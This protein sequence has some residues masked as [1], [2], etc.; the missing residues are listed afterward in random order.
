MKDAGT[1]IASRWIWSLEQT[2]SRAAQSQILDYRGT[3][4]AM[5][6][7]IEVVLKASK[8]EKHR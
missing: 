4:R 8:A 2:A 5:H 1:W 3:G 6:A 7:T